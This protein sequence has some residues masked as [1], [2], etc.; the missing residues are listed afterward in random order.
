MNAKQTI[1]TRTKCCEIWGSCCSG[2]WRRV[3]LVGRYQ[4]FGETCCLHLQPWRWRQFI[5][6]KRYLP[7]T[8]HGVTTQNNNIVIRKLWLQITS[9]KTIRETWKDLREM[10]IVRIWKVVIER[11]F[12]NAYSEKTKYMFMSRHHT[13]GQ[14]NYIRVTNKSFEKWQSSSI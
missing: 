12:F 11:R 13:A 9:E 6:P 2:L 10:S 5:S 4:R 8:P 7:T 14:S 1:D 3:V